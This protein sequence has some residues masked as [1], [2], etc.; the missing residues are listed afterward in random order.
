MQLAPA[1]R[2]PDDR[3]GFLDRDPLG[4]ALA[5]ALLE[6]A[7]PTRRL[8]FALLPR[9]EPLG[10]TIRAHGVETARLAFP[11]LTLL[12]ASD[13]AVGDLEVEAVVDG[14]D[15]LRRWGGRG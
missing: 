15:L 9:P 4:A 11:P 2:L 7:G 5:G 6:V 14:D 13:R 10:A 8:P 1:S 12:D 3:R